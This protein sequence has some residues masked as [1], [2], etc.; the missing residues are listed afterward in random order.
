MIKN[1]HFDT[2]D[3]NEMAE[4]MGLSYS[5]HVSQELMDQIKTN[6]F[7]ISL[8]IQYSGRIKSILNI[9]RSNLKPKNGGVKE[10]IPKEGIVFPLAIAKGPLIKEE[11]ITIRAEMKEDGGET[12]I[13]LTAVPEKN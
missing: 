9:L 1:D 8:G 3:V 4:A 6:D 5:V 13:L 11:I 7:L 12:V 10:E 2:G